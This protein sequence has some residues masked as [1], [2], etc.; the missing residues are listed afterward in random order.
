M[1]M[2]TYF[3]RRSSRKQRAFVLTFKGRS[4]IQ[5][6]EVNRGCFVLSCRY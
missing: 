4:D 3:L 2:G 1:P 6:M 5:H